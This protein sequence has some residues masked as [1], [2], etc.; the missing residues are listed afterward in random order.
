MN[1]RLLTISGFPREIS[2]EKDGPLI[3]GRDFSNQVEVR[4][5]AVS[6]KHCSLS[7]VSSGIFEIVDLDSRNGTFVN[8][9]QV[10]RH[11]IQHGD[12]VRIGSSEFVFLTGLD[13]EDV[14]SSSGSH[15]AGAE[16]KTVSLDPSGLPA[17]ASRMSSILRATC[18]PW[19][20]ICS[21]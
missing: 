7:E 13:D 19:S 18:R 17:D 5:P 11:I 2:V 12:R 20:A 4:D 3:L 9:T 6:R 8:G 15:A 1:P 10:S 21:G 16:C 14:L